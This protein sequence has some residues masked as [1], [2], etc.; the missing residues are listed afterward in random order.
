[1]VAKAEQMEKVESIL[2][3]FIHYGKTELVDQLDL[4]LSELLVETLQRILQV[5]LDKIKKGIDCVSF[6]KPHLQDIF[7]IT[8][9]C[10]ATFQSFRLQGKPDPDNIKQAKLNVQ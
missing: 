1:M 7:V 2:Q 6:I 8:M 3:E 10:L 9:R 5:Y 4:E